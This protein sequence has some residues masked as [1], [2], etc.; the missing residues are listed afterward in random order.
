M[1]GSVSVFEP[2]KNHLT[3]GSVRTMAH[4]ADVETELSSCLFSCLKRSASATQ[5]YFFFFK[6]E[7]EIHR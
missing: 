4:S 1:V 2:Q 5:V 3:S 7:V 6:Q